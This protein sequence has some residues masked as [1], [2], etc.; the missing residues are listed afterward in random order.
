MPYILPALPYSTS[1]LEPFYDKATLELHYNKHHAGYV[2][3]LNETLQSYPLLLDYTV[4]ELLGNLYSLPSVFR[5]EVSHYG[6]GHANHSLFWRSM[7][8]YNESTTF[9]ELAQAIPNTFGSFNN[10]KTAFTELSMGIFGS[11][12][13]IW[14]FN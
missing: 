11:G 5:S 9:G 1:S 3:K 14:M 10:F 13:I 6:G 2:A 7:T 4:E 8:P 12:W